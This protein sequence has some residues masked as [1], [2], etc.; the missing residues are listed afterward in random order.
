MDFSD[1][2]CIRLLILL[3]QMQHALAAPL[4]QAHPQIVSCD[5]LIQSDIWYLSAV[6]NQDCVF[7]A[8]HLMSV[9]RKQEAI[10]VH[11][12]SSARAMTANDCALHTVTV[13][14]MCQ[15]RSIKCMLTCTP[16]S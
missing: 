11:R 10:S 9:P 6:C 13:T 15:L 4:P 2:N 12:Q 14:H 7:R 16:Q 3:L 1:R 8:D 5:V